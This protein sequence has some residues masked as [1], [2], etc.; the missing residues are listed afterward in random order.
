MLAVPALQRFMV[1]H[2]LTRA[3]LSPGPPGDTFQRPMVWDFIGA[4]GLALFIFA[5]SRTG[6]KPTSGERSTLATLQ[7]SCL[8]ISKPYFFPA[9]SQ[10]MH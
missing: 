2:R 10:R 3:S 6:S 7:V 1:G 5:T 8:E 9:P 4:A